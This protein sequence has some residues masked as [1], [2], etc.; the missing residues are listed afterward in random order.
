MGYLIMYIDFEHLKE[1]RKFW[2]RTG[3]Q[4]VPPIDCSCGAQGSDAPPSCSVHPDGYRLT[5][6]PDSIIPANQV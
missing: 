4:G 2:I 1:L 3:H 6:P 5:E